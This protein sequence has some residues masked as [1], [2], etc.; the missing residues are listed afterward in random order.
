MAA[1]SWVESVK[2][3]ALP[4][5]ASM[6]VLSSSLF[7]DTANRRNAVMSSEVA[8]ALFFSLAIELVKGW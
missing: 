5:M 4:C 1:H 8:V 2:R 3:L 7:S 6:N